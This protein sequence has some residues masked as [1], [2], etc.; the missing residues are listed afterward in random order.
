MKERIKRVLLQTLI[1]LCFCLL[2]DIKLV[3]ADATGYMYVYFNLEDYATGKSI[4]DSKDRLVNWNDSTCIENKDAYSN[5][6]INYYENGALVKSRII[7]EEEVG[8]VFIGIGEDEY[9]KGYSA[10]AYSATLN[11]LKAK[12][13]EQNILFFEN[14]KK[15]EFEIIPQQ[16]YS[17]DLISSKARLETSGSG[18]VLLSDKTTPFTILGNRISFTFDNEMKHVIS[19]PGCGAAIHL[20]YYYRKSTDP[21]P[22][23]EKITNNVKPKQ[24]TSVKATVNTKKRTVKIT[25][26]K[27]TDVTGYKV[28]IAKNKSFTKNKKTYTIKNYKTSSK[29][30]SNLKK[31]TYYVRVRAYKISDKSNLY[32][33]YSKV[34]KIILK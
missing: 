1:M 28:E 12:A 9:M 27:D 22:T 11:S 5:L 10:S 6:R 16:G 19:T 8:K 25:W 31:G 26:K 15:Y 21:A 4:Y 14:G 3:S 20:R 18:T 13:E 29:T 30:I 17:L 7:D 33:T 2:L 32:G 23:T 24:V 34:R